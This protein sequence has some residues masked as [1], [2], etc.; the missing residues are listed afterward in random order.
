MQPVTSCTAADIASVCNGRDWEGDSKKLFILSQE[1]WLFKNRGLL[2][3]KIVSRLAYE[4]HYTHKY[5]YAA[6]H[7]NSGSTDGS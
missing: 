5:C 7:I 1:D 6:V 3:G 4:Y 2:E